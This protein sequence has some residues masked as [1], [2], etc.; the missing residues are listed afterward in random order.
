MTDSLFGLL[1]FSIFFSRI[2]SDLKECIV[3]YISSSV[4][5]TSPLLPKKHKKQFSSCQ[6]SLPNGCDNLLRAY[7]DDSSLSEIQIEFSIQHVTST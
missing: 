7:K 4:L 5:E 1:G 2:F 3:S 6:N